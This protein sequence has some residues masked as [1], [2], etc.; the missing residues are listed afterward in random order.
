M[1]EHPRLIN[2]HMKVLDQYFFLYT[3]LPCFI[4]NVFQSTL[5]NT[6]KNIKD[7]I[8]FLKYNFRLWCQ[9]YRGSQFY[10]W[11]IKYNTYLI[12]LCYMYYS[13]DRI[14]MSFICLYKSV[15]FW[16]IYPKNNQ[17][18]L[19]IKLCFSK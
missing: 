10:L 12:S 11:T 19:D 9:L 8:Q 17:T 5:L 14:C 2:K 15:V 18:L 16:I 7:S 4:Q 3:E 13:S 6:N 1:R